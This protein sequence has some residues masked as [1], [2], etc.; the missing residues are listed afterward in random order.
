MCFCM[1]ITKP[2]MLNVGQPIPAYGLYCKIPVSVCG[3][4]RFALH[5][6]ILTKR[7]TGNTCLKYVSALGEKISCR[8]RRESY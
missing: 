1:N 4:F 5:K 7:Q 2:F 6:I 3:S 8:V